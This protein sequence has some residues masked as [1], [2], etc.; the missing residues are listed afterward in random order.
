M[1]KNIKIKVNNKL[2]NS[3]Q[4]TD[5]YNRQENAT[6]NIQKKN[7]T[8]IKNLF[9]S[10]WAIL[11][12]FVVSYLYFSYKQDNITPQQHVANIAG[13]S[14]VQVAKLANPTK[15]EKRYVSALIMGI[16]TRGVK[17][18]GEKY[19]PIR[20]DGTRKIDVIMQVVYDRQKNK[21]I[22]I[23]IPRDTSLPVTEECMHQEREDQK[24]INRIYDMAEKNNCPEDGASMM[25]KYVS[26]I[27]GFDID[28][29]TIVT[30]DTFVELIDIVG[31]ENNGKKGMWVDVPRNIYDY[32]PNDH[33][34]YDYVVFKKGRQ[35]L[36]PKQVLCFVRVRKASS[37]FDRN[38]RQQE[39]ISEVTNR[40]MTSET[41]S[42]PKKLY[43]IYKKF[44]G[45]MQMSKIGLKDIS[46]AIEILSEVDL[47]NI[48]KIVLDYEFGGVNGLLVKPLYSRPGTHTRSGYYLIP[49]HW[50]DECCKNDEWRYVREYLQALIEDPTLEAR[51]ASVYAYVS[52]Y[53]GGKAVF[54]NQTYQMLKQ[55]LQDEYLFINES[56]YPKQMVYKGPE[57]QI[58]DFTN[59][60]KRNVAEHIAEI[61]GGKVYEGKFAP[62]KVAPNREEISIV[63]KVN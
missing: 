38:R 20:R 1:A 35:F 54:D 10:F 3:D 30:L 63:V 16:D 21:L 36:T 48:Q 19:I 5:V 44:N 59:G 42:D 41:L 57:I 13:K 52:K 28:Y 47:D 4:S 31:E 58:F 62:F 8:F 33:Y 43:D 55:T 15:A 12:V 23:S 24:Y 32:C 49:S 7:R 2:I 25:E 39:L 61:S 26:Y 60:K 18:D 22:F 45:K 51:T 34:G 29:Y 11:L 14:V 56:K 9:L 17:F 37:D 50:N 6:Q 46:L 27:T 40:I 53:T